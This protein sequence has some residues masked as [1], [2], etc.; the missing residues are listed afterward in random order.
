MTPALLFC[1][2][3]LGGSITVVYGQTEHPN[4]WKIIADTYSYRRLLENSFWT[5]RDVDGDGV[6][7]VERGG[8]SR[9]TLEVCG[10]NFMLDGTE[11]NWVSHQL[12]ICK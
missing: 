10:E 3:V 2:A 1:F 7:F 12:W 8:I 5:T 6:E 4:N 11:D 9:S